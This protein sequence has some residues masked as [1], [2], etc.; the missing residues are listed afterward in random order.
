MGMLCADLDKLNAYDDN[1]FVEDN[2]KTII[3]VRLLVW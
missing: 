2:P 1:N 3:H